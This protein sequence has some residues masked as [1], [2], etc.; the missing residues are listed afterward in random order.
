MSMLIMFI[1][2]LLFSIIQAIPRISIESKEIQVETNLQVRTNYGI[3][4]GFSYN[5]SSGKNADIFMG[6]PYAEPPIEELRLE[7]CKLESYRIVL[8]GIN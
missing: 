4:E 8:W 2:V 5:T 1:Y 7:V 6:I 3:V